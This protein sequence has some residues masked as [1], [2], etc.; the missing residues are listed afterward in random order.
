LIV[1]LLLTG[2]P[3]AVHTSANPIQSATKDCKTS[4][5]WQ[6]SLV[7]MPMPRINPSSSNAGNLYQA[8]TRI[9]RLLA[10]ELSKTLGIQS[11]FSLLGSRQD[12]NEDSRRQQVRDLA[13]QTESQFVLSGEILDMSMRDASTVYSP[14]LLQRLRNHFTDIT[15]MKFADNRDRHFSLRLELRDGFTGELLMTKQFQ[16]SGIWKN[17]KTTGFD[18]PQ[19]WS[20]QYGRRIKKLLG[21]ASLELANSLKCQPY[22]AKVESRPGQQDMIL[23]GGANNG[24]KAGDQLK[25]YQLVVLGSDHYETY[26]TRLIKRDLQLQ[27]REVYPSHSVGRLIGDD[28]MNGQYLAVG[29]E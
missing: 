15:L 5:H 1:L 8:E 19:L 28:L 3:C 18:S 29:E 16:T 6:K 12:L 9:P 20:S 24:L 10:A 26:R 2:L 27:L 25:L 13:A 22:M 14:H 23:Q 4:S 7:I 21:N 11:N 17:A